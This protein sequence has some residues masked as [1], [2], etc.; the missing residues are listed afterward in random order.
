L[1]IKSDEL[2][3]FL[4]IIKEFSQMAQKLYIQG[5]R[6]ALNGA[7]RYGTRYQKQ[8]SGTLTGPQYACLVSTLQAIADCLALLGSSI[9]V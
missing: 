8:L 6:V 4:P 7:H 1:T 9:P 2:T 5:L 3:I